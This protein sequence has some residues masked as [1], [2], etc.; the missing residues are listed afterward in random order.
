MILNI[1]I[2][3]MPAKRRKDTTWKC[4]H[5]TPTYCHHKKELILNE[6]YECTRVNWT[7]QSI[8]GSHSTTNFFFNEDSFKIN[9][10]NTMFYLEWIR[11]R[12]KSII[13]WLGY[14]ILNVLYAR[15]MQCC[16]Y[17]III[18]ICHRT[19]NRRKRDNTKKR[20]H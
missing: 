7:P 17:S 18:N 11:W 20:Q 9:L 19:I 6:Y 1:F 8:M 14:G 5:K 3:S 10:Q 12:K 2:M 15:L 13:V 4:L 16:K